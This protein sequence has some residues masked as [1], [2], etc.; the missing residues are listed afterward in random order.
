VAQAN[1][2]RVLVIAVAGWRIPPLAPEAAIIAVSD[3]RR[4]TAVGSRE[5]VAASIATLAAGTTAIKPAA[6]DQEDEPVEE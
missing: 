3:G 5:A 2:G 1:A 6:E 4:L